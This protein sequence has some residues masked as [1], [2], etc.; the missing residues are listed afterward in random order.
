MAQAIDRATES[1]R[2]DIAQ[3]AAKANNTAVPSVGTMIA[4]ARR[5]NATVSIFG[6]GYALPKWR[7]TIVV[8]KDL[9]AGETEGLFTFLKEKDLPVRVEVRQ[10]QESTNTVEQSMWF[11]I[12]QHAIQEMFVALVLYSLWSLMKAIKLKTL[13]LDLRNS[14]FILALIATMQCI[15]SV[16]IYVDTVLKQVTRA[17]R[18]FFFDI[19]FYL[20]FQLWAK[21]LAQAHSEARI[22]VFSVLV[23]IASAAS[24]AVYVLALLDLTNLRIQKVQVVFFKGLM[25]L[26]I[27]CAF[28]VYGIRFLIRRKRGMF[29]SAPT[30]KALKKLAILALIGASTYVVQSIHNLF[31][32][33]ER[34]H[35]VFFLVMTV[36]DKWLLNLVRAAA[37]LLVFGVTIPE[38]QPKKPIV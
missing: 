31:N 14:I 9:P 38:R 15:F 7:T 35:P 29:V 17:G 16:S 6:G 34:H 13:R 19:A 27:A 23:V 4:Y 33:Y 2:A 8:I 25:D 21:V 12:L 36:V 20:L 3:A 11:R 37:L 1:L 10:E 28:L 22:T 32:E 30:Q 26:I 18:H 24:F 5:A